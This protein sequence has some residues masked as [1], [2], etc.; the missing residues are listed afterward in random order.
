MARRIAEFATDS[1][2]VNFFT[3]FNKKIIIFF[4]NSMIYN[5][6]RRG[7]SVFNEVIIKAAPGSKIIKAIGGALSSIDIK[8]AG[9]FIILVIIFNTFMLIS[10]GKGFDAFSMIARIA[11][12]ILGLTLILKKK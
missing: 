10:F 12:F 4:Y 8:D 7:R 2:I 6:F 9:F 11:F 5:I 1:K 3:G